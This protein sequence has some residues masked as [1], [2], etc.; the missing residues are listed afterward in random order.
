MLKGK[1]TIQREW[2]CDDFDSVFSQS[3][4]RRWQLPWN[5]SD[6]KEFW[7]VRTKYF[8][9]TMQRE[10]AGGAFDDGVRVFKP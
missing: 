4:L 6:K 7:D 8:R 9:I 10:K 2:M 3:L 1:W 5:T